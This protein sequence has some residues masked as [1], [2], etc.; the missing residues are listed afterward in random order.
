MKKSTFDIMIHGRGVNTKKQ[1]NGLI[2]TFFGLHKEDG[3]KITH[4][5]TGFGIPVKGLSYTKCKELI[6][7]FENS[8]IDWSL[9]ES[10]LATSGASEKTHKIYLEVLNK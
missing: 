9:P 2:S 7:R 8:D 5:P 4:I 6:T 10:K 3:Y 1:V